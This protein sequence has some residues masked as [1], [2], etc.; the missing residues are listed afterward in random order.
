MNSHLLPLLISYRSRGEKLI[1]YKATDSSR[2]IISV[3]SDEH[4]V[5]QSSDIARRNLMLSLL[6]LKGLKFCHGRKE[7]LSF[8]FLFSEP[9]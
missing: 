9:D 7:N 8:V 1:E 4:S 5:L 3:S 6:G 2:V